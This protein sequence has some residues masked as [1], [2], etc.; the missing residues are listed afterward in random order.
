MK[1]SSQEEY[2]LRCAIQ[3]GRLG[4]ENSL[5]I[6]EMS[7]L[8][9]LNTTHV[10]KILMILRRAGFV[11]STRGQS[12]GYSIALAPNEI[13]LKDLL[14]A[15]GGRLYDQEFCTKHAGAAEVCAHDVDCAVRSLWQVL[16]SSVDQVLDRM[17]LADLIAPTATVSRANLAMLPMVSTGTL[18]RRN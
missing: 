10:A 3:L 18:S 6:P 14:E 8:E 4:T 7:K 2:G 1:F 9:G 16:Q 13:K 15:L 17:T 11:S 12:G 5:T